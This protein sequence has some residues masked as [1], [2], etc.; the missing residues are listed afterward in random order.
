M[1]RLPLY[2]RRLTEAKFTGSSIIENIEASGDDLQPKENGVLRFAFQ[3]IHGTTDL[4]GW[5]VPSEIEAIEE[6]E[7]DIM[8][9]A[10]T[11]RPWSTHQRSLFNAYM[12]NRFRSSRTN[13]TAA[14]ST[15]HRV[16]YQPGGNL[17]TINGEV[18]AR[19][20]GQ[21]TDDLGR[22]CWYKL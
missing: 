4:Q 9:M 15:D 22:F 7:I 19:I 11:N 17:L 10:E 18:T 2:Q 3:N 16:K 13:F 21:G 5:E 20:D 12:Q 14:P 8:G 1:T 6:F